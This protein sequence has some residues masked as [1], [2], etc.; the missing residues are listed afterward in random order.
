MPEVQHYLTP[1]LQCTAP[2]TVPPPE[3]NSRVN[4]RQW[5]LLTLYCSV[6]PPTDKLIRKYLRAHLQRCGMDC[7]SE[8]GKYARYAEKVGRVSPPSSEYICARY[9]YHCL[10]L[11]YVTYYREVVDTL[12]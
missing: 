11:S 8:E 3:R 2:N 9:E 4:L 1:C 10:N 5:A 12:S 6:I 7:V